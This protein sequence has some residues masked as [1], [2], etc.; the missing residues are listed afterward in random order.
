MQPYYVIDFSASA[1]MFEIRVNDYPVILMDVSGQVSS[2]IP[3]NFAILEKG[4]QQISAKILP[5]S[6]KKELAKEAEL[7]FGIKLFDVTQDFVLKDQFGDYQSKPVEDKELPVIIYENTFLAD[8]PYRLQAWQDGRNLKDIDKCREK[9]EKAYQR[10]IT[11]LKNGE[12]EVYQ[13]LIEKRE[14][15]MSESMYLSKEEADAR[16]KG[17]IREFGSGMKIRPLPEDAL[18]F[19][20]A[21]NRVAALKRPNG[22]S[23]LSLVNEEKQEE[24]MLDVSF[25]IPE[26][27]E[28]FEII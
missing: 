3:V 15:N 8:V 22:D 24:L 21:E 26:G 27:K 12:F 11:V 19:F 6:G 10:L 5:L 20:Y 18:M 16:M 13:K 2:M 4:E 9:L 14:K 17:L 28:E 7:K 23:A 25:F 1:C